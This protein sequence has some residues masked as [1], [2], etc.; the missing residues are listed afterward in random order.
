VIDWI[1]AAPAILVA[2]AVATIPG[3]PTAWALRLRGLPLL[4][5]A[6]AASFAI[7]AVA[8][9]VAP[10]LGLRWG[11]IPVLLIAAVV[12]ALAFVLRRAI[13]PTSAPSPGVSR[14]V[15]IG[16]TVGALVIAAA[17]IGQELARAIDSPQNI[18]QTYDGVFH[19]NA[20]AQILSTGDASPLH[21]NLAYPERATLLYPTLWHATVALTAQLS[22][23]GVTVATNAVA[24]AVAAWVWPVAILFFASPFFV[25]RPH[26][27]LLG[28]LLAS[29]FTAF[30]YLLLA[31]GVLYPNYLATALLPIAL[32]ALHLALRYRELPGNHVIGGPQPLA[33]LWVVFL[34]AAGAAALAHPNT[35]FG[36]AALAIPLLISTAWRLRR[37]DL[38]RRNITWRLIGLSVAL[39]GIAVLWCTISAYESRG[40]DSSLVRGIAS[41]LTNAP[42]LDAKAWVLSLLVLAGAAILLILVRRHRWILAAYAIAVLLFAVTVGMTGPLRDFLTGAWYNDAARLAALL[43]IAALPLAGV[44]GAWLLDLVNDRLPNPWLGVAGMTVV[45]ALILVGARG[46]SIAAQSGWIG[47]LYRVSPDSPLLS[48]DERK[49][50]ERLPAEVPE[51]S[52]IA[53]DPWTGTALAF[54]LSGR[55]VVFPHLKGEFGTEAMELAAEFESLEKPEACTLL[56]ALDIDFVLDF[57]GPVYQSGSDATL[58]FEGLRGVS[59][60]PVLEP[61]DREG[62]AALY[63][64]QC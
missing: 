50:I 29:V 14:R 53:G 15:I 62:E 23:T 7:I 54:A 6:V 11:V 38:S 46:S 37:T 42:L 25:R 52:L 61:V 19:L 28:G 34:G 10:L 57:G 8:S 26:H 27:L 1:A 43:P 63:R 16:T 58:R 3:L 35:L 40:Y 30:P 21:M 41:A 9:I 44:A 51:G 2:T 4:A 59:D 49:L 64:V 17:L 22:G 13:S 18:S 39:I 32:G 45:C 5:A 56:D 31:W 55:E 36:L 24:V 33:S 20:V 47:E 60:S 48:P 12:A